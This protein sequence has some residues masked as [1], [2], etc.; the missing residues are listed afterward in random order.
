MIT[1]KPRESGIT[2][3]P[4]ISR[5]LF[6]RLGTYAMALCI[7]WCVARGV[8]L[9]QLLRN[10]SI[11]DLWVF[12]P[13]SAGSFTIWF[14]GETFLFA[15][16]FSYSITVPVFARCCRLTLRNIFCSWLIPLWPGPRS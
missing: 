6:Y 15:T 14:V 2:H 9:S 10:F 12:I 8:S 3:R 5:A 11:A 1:L 7:I 16:L 13:A 4:I